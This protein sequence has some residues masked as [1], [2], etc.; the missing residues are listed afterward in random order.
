[1]GAEVGRLIDEFIDRQKFPPN[2]AW[3]A[4][5]VGVSKSTVTNWHRDGVPRPD[6]LRRLAHV[7]ETPY[8]RLVDAVMVDLGYIESGRSGEGSGQQPAA[9][10]EA[11]GDT[12]LQGMTPAAW[13]ELARVLGRDATRSQFGPRPETGELGGVTLDVTAGQASRSR[14]RLG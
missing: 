11:R 5:Q 1:M 9:S 13:D 2:A 3:V 8:S 7:I 14:K 6:L 12:G 4:R 10:S